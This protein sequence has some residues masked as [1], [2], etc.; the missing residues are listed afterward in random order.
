MVFSGWIIG[1]NVCRLSEIVKRFFTSLMSN[2]L[3]EYITYRRCIDHARIRR[4]YALSE[5][6]IIILKIYNITFTT[7]SEKCFGRRLDHSCAISN[8]MCFLMM[9]ASCA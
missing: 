6:L 9:P 1:A 3:S 8:K 4:D 5:K 2:A 7:I